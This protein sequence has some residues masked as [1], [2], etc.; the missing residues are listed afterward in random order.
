MEE[1]EQLYGEQVMFHP[2][3][4]CCVATSLQPSAPDALTR[5]HLVERPCLLHEYVDPTRLL[6]ASP[7]AGRVRVTGGE[8][9][10]WRQH[11]LRRYT[12]KAQP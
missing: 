1:M 2:G 8:A 6:P 4:L 3:I 5:P 7:P 12:K 9:P 10:G 11:S